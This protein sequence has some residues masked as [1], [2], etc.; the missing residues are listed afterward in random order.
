MLH[1]TYHYRR[2]QDR[3]HKRKL[4]D[5]A[6]YC[7]YPGVMEKNG[8]YISCGRGK[9]SKYLKNLGNRKLRRENANAVHS[10]GSYK[11]VFDY[12]WELT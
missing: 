1:K 11:K 12:W 3:K 10:G 6:S 8:Y 5:I 7:G 9:V 2:M 4:K